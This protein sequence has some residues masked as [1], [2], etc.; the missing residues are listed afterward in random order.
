[1]QFHCSTGDCE[2]KSDTSGCPVAI[3]CYAVERIENTRERLIG[4]A[5]AIIPDD[6]VAVFPN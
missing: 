4:N 3:L 5:W 6:D 2:A 1:M